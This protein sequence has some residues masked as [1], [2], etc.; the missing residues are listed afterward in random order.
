M[1]RAQESFRPNER[2]KQIKTLGVS[3]RVRWWEHIRV[4]LQTII[5]SHENCSLWRGS[6]VGK[7]AKINQRAE[8][9]LGKRTRRPL[10]SPPASFPTPSPSLHSFSSLLTF[11]LLFPRQESLFTGY[12]IGE[13]LPESRREDAGIWGKMRVRLNSRH[14][15]LCGWGFSFLIDP[16]TCFSLL[17][18]GILL[19]T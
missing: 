7:S 14:L 11:L 12:R 2:I 15:L 13:K 1:T 17:A 10:P 5:E 16:C 8:R 4:T 9:R 18:P 6:A 19:D 3:L